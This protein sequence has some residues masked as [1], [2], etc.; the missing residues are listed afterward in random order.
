MIKVKIIDLEKK[1]TIDEI[2]FA[3]DAQ[4][5]EAINEIKEPVKHFTDGKIEIVTEEAESCNTYNKSIM[6][7]SILLRK[8]S[9]VNSYKNN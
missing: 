4:T 6:I 5:F 8:I 7:A 3:Y 1:Q 2:L 9:S